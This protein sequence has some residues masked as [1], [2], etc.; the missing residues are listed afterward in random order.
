[1]NSTISDAIDQKNLLTFFYDGGARTVEPYC[2][3]IGTKGHELLRGYQID[4]YSSS[5]KLGWRLFKVAD[6]SS[7]ETEGSFE[8]NRPDYKKGDKQIPNIFNEI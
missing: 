8:A 2:Y 4:G 6:M 7:I 1:M 5:G 3:G